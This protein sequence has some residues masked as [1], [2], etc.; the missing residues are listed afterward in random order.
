M[1]PND[2][3]DWIHGVEIYV[4]DFFFRDT[5]NELIISRLEGL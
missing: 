3:H 1:T 4:A 5:L 2:I